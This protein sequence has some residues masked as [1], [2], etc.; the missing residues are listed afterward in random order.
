L[1]CRNVPNSVSAKVNELTAFRDERQSP[2]MGGRVQGWE[3]ES[4][5]GRQSPGM[6]G[7]GGTF[8]GHCIVE[9]EY[10]TNVTLTLMFLPTTYP[11]T[12]SVWTTQITVST[13]KRSGHPRGSFKRTS[14]GSNGIIECKFLP[15]NAH[16]TSTSCAR[17]NPVS[18]PSSSSAV[19]VPLA[20]DGASIDSTF[21]V[22][23][24]CTVG[25]C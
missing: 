5:D 4:R 12:F 13:D 10:H 15:E 25:P 16:R 17:I 14:V 7:M 9:I 1:I 18:L 6:S 22:S 3:A 8:M 2:G 11:F 20:G 19:P 24:A 23:A 21:S